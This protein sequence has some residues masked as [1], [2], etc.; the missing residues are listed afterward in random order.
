M[1]RDGKEVEEM[2]PHW[3]TNQ[4]GKRIDEHDKLLKLADNDI[5]GLLNRV[6]DA[7]KRLARLVRWMEANKIIPTGQL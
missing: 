5:L 2:S 4:L 3:R 1:I 7:E 6:D